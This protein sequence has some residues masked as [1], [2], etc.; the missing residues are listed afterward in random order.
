LFL[1]RELFGVT[2]HFA[3]LGIPRAAWLDPEE[4]KERFHR[5]SAQRHP[6]AAG[7]T[8]QAFTDLNDAWQT[9]RDPAKCLRHYLE[10]EHPESLAG[11]AQTPPELAGLFMDIAASRQSAQKLGTKLAE[12][13][14][15][16]TRALLEPERIAQRAR[17]DSLNANVVAR[18]AQITA[19]VRAGTLTPE[20]LATSLASLVF[21]GKWT[22]QLGEMRLV[23]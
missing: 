20:Q 22:A 13:T 16:L 1:R 17:L 18:T 5:L 7:G 4:L 11:T 23:L 15:P 21:L 2:D 19:A 6:D 12:A 3:V 9:L 14:S 8:A 10:L